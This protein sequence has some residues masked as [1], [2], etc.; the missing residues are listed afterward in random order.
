[1]KIF[2]FLGLT[3]CCFDIQSIWVICELDMEREE[4]T[5]EKSNIQDVVNEH[6]VHKALNMGDVLN[7]PS[8]GDTDSHPKCHFLETLK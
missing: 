7:P 4:C 1:M 6:E 2:K 5:E 8:T 3:Y